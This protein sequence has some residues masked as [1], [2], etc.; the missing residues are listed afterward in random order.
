MSKPKPF[1]RTINPRT[2]AMIVIGV[3]DEGLLTWRL[4]MMSENAQRALCR[5]QKDIVA[6]V[7]MLIARIGDDIK[8]APLGPSRRQT[9]PA[10]RTAGNAEHERTAV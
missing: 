2:I 4:P 7:D 6:L 9:R 10:N 8:T 3:T 5:R 1:E